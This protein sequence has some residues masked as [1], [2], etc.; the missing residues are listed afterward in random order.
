[1][2]IFPPK[3]LSRS[4]EK[5]ERNV[6]P[7]FRGFMACNSVTLASLLHSIYPK[8]DRARAGSGFQDLSGLSGADSFQLVGRVNGVTLLAQLFSISCFNE[9]GSDAGGC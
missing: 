1:M 5:Q 4:R 7:L 2:I 9:A 6:V 3:P 8:K